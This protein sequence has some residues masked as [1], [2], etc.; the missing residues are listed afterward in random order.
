M[1][2]FVNRKVTI[3][4]ASCLAVAGIGGGAAYAYWTVGG[5][6]TGSATAGSANAVQIQLS[7]TVSG[8][9][10]GGA[11]SALAGTFTNPNASP[12]RIGQVTVSIAPSFSAQADVSK[13]ACTAADFVLTQPAATN[14]E[15]TTGTTW[16]GG[17][18]AMSNL[19]TNQD[20]CKNV[21]V[22]LVFS[23]A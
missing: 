14:A 2:T 20:N 10:P 12:V 4:V 17:S 5:S 1:R 11:A 19:A 18:I 8:L 21:T 16:A 22:P 3:A 23:A 13:P 15:V 7:G 9:V 6:G